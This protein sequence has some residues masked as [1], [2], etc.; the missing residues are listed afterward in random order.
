MVFTLLWINNFRAYKLGTMKNIILCADDYGQNTAI[1]QAIIDLFQKKRLSATSCMTTSYYW[2]SHAKWLR[3]FAEEFDVGLHFNLTEGKSLSKE[4]G[5]EFLPLSELIMK[6]YL[7]RL[8]QRDI[9]LEL[10]AQLDA[11]MDEMGCEPHFLDGH[12]HIHQLPVV[13]NALLNVYEKRFRSKK[14]Y[15]RA[16][17]NPRSLWQFKHNAYVKNL[18]IQSCG[19]FTLKK[20]LVK[21]KISH[22]TSFSGI[23]D[24]S[25]AANY[26]A[27]FPYFLNQVGNNGIIMCHPGQSSLDSEDEIASARVAEYMYFLS[28]KFLETWDK[29]HLGRLI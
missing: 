7:R 21:N 29:F 9:E 1:S 8:K 24:F 19:S 27:I 16:V 15:I 18:I 5:P 17:N 12:Q 25:Q 14:V 20:L 22:N 28:D 13:R 2:P 3:P 26:A 11:F 4:M 23:Y 10:N 6:A